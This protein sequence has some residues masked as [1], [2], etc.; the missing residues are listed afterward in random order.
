MRIASIALF[1]VWASSCCKIQTNFVPIKELS[2]EAFTL[3]EVDTFYVL[4]YKIDKPLHW[5][6]YA[7][8]RQ[9]TERMT[10]TLK[11][12]Q[13]KHSL[14]IEIVLKD[15]SKRFIVQ[16]TKSASLREGKG[17]CAPMTIRIEAF[18]VNGVKQMG[19]TIR[20]KK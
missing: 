10:T 15:T 11:G 8:Y 4:P 5:N 17:R 12:L 20:I 13:L 7:G 18:E 6:E 14:P 16:D 2:F 19:D 3:S 9:T 1:I